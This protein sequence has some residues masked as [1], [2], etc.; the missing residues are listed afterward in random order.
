V[1]VKELLGYDASLV[2]TTP[3]YAGTGAAR[4]ESV[5]AAEAVRRL[6]P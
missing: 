1:D 2:E 4:I 3:L 6:T 5:A